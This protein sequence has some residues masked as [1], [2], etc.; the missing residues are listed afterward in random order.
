MNKTNNN[1]I[2]NFKPQNQKKTEQIKEENLTNQQKQ[3]LLNNKSKQKLNTNSITNKNKTNKIELTQTK[4]FTKFFKEGNFTK[5]DLTHFS[6]LSPKTQKEILNNQANL[7]TMNEN[8]FQKK[9]NLN[10][11][12]NENNGED[13]ICK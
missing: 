3:N 7:I 11:N 5:K 1:P 2:I 9:I 8:L 12:I 4:E 6:I 13:I 10:V